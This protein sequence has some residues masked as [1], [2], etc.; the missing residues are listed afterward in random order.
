MLSLFLTFTFGYLS[1]IAINVLLDSP[2]A[3]YTEICLEHFR[4]P[5]PVSVWKIFLLQ[6]PNLLHLFGLIFDIKLVKLVKSTIIPTNK[7]NTEPTPT[8]DDV[9]LQNQT[10]QRK[11]NRTVTFDENPSSQSSPIKLSNIFKIYSF[12]HSWD[13]VEKIPIQASIFSSIL[14]F[15][16]L[17]IFILTH[18]FEL[19]DGN[20]G[21]LNRSALTFST[22][23]RCP[24]TVL[25]T[26]KSNK[27]PSQAM[28]QQELDDF[29]SDERF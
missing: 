19:E 12:N 28:E 8:I 21:I 10:T 5:R 13:N 11:N 6:L 23:I 18:V 15:P 16:Y 2:Y 4:G 27:R 24:L 25:M 17:F 3:A 9:N 7:L 22:A 29:K 14:I 1:Y 26:Y 20:R